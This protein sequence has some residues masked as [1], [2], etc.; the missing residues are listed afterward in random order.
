[1]YPFMHWCNSWWYSGTLFR[2]LLNLLWAPL[3]L[4]ITPTDILKIHLNR[5][6]QPNHLLSQLPDAETILAIVCPYVS[7]ADSLT[8]FN[9][10]TSDR[11][12]SIAHIFT[13]RFCMCIAPKIFWKKPMGLEE[14]QNN[15]NNALIHVCFFSVGLYTKVVTLFCCFFYSGYRDCPLM[16]VWWTPL[17]N[18]WKKTRYKIFKS[19]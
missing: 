10:A 19:G 3:P 18:S 7:V 16:L 12:D 2:V 4:I 14:E 5:Y 6:V 17:P 9:I 15:K 8:T 1:M 13:R 11:P